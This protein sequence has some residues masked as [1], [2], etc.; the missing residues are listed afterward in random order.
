MSSMLY[1]K[2]NYKGLYINNIRQILGRLRFVHDV[3]LG[4]PVAMLRATVDMAKGSFPGPEETVNV[5]GRTKLSDIK[6]SLSNS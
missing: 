4:K 6:S 1:G 3:G 2:Y 5:I